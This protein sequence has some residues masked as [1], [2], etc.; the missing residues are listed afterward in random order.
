MMNFFSRRWTLAA[1]ARF[2]ASEQRLVRAHAPRAYDALDR[3]LKRARRLPL[4]NVRER[5]ASGFMAALAEVPARRR[6]TSPRRQ[7]A[8]LLERAR[9]GPA[10]SDALPP[11]LPSGC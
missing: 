1:L 3:M 9:E 10:L 4:G 5:Y 8:R 11:P 7:I 6:P 2:H